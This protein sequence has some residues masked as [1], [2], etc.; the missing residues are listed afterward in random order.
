MKIYIF[1]FISCEHFDSFNTCKNS[2]GLVSIATEPENTIIAYPS[3]EQ[4]HVIVKT[5]NSHKESIEK[6]VDFLI[7]TPPCHKSKGI[8]KRF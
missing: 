1:D 3:E 8:E 4:G 2:S 7:A 5:Y 6:E